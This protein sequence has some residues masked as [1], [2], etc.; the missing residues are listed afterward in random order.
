MKLVENLH[1][2]NIRGD[3]TGGITAGVVALP[4]AIAMGLASGAGAIAGLY[5]AIITLLIVYLL[6]KKIGKFI[7][8]PLFG[9]IV[10]T[11]ILL[12]FPEFFSSN[13]EPLNKMVLG[14]IP[15]GLPSFQLPVWDMSIIF[16][17]VASP[18]YG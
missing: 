10:G 15:T 18:M 5:G 8:S 1:F 3:I 4:F 12:L 9:L 6:P 7:P 13:T 11:L 17:M 16:D 14:D 2:N